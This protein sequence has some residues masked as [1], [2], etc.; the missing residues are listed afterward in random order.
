MLFTSWDPEI[1]KDFYNILKSIP[2]TN[3]MW[4]E[5]TEVIDIELYEIIWKKQVEN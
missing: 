2:I 1:E 5:S 4:L 3:T